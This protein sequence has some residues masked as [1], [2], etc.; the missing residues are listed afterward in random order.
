MATITRDESPWNTVI[1]AVCILDIDMEPSGDC[2]Q[3]VLNPQVFHPDRFGTPFEIT[4]NPVTVTTTNCKTAT[5][6]STIIG[7]VAV[8]TFGG[9]V[10]VVSVVHVVGGFIFARLLVMIF[11]ATLLFGCWAPRLMVSLGVGVLGADL[12]AEGAEGGIEFAI[13][14]GINSE[15][16]NKWGNVRMINT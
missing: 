6:P 15:N 2:P 16:R 10:Q 4:V 12:G 8:D 3:R 1:L 9:I 5:D 13:H 11:F 14:S 7:R